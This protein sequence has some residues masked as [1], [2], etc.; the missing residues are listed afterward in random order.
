MRLL[1]ALLAAILCPLPG[2]A[3][4]AEKPNIIVIM[5]DDLGYGD[6]GCYGAKPKDLKTPHIDR[7]AANGLR[8]TSGYCS[9]STCTPTRFSFLTGKYAFR[10]KNTGIAPPNGPAIIQPGVETLPSLLKRAGYTTAVIGK[11]HLGLGGPGGPDWNGDLKPGPLEIG[12]DH[13]FLLPTTNDRVPQVYVEN[14]RV[15]NLDP[16]DPLWVGRK[17]PSPDH[18]TGLT[19][20]DTLKMDWSHGHNSTIHNGISRIGFYTGGH[21]ARFRDEDLA[22]EWVKQSNQWI[23]ANKANPFF[24]FFSSHD[25]HVPRIP[26]ERFHGTSGLGFRGDAI[27]Q[28]DWCVGELV[29]T[30]DRLKLSDNTLI[31]FCSD[32]GPVGDDG[33]KDDALEKMGDHQPGGPFSGGKY[34]VLEGGTR[35]PFI[36]HWPGRIAPGVT[37]EMV[38]TIDFAASFAALTG[39]E[40]PKDA[41]PD[42]FDVIDALLGK[43]GAKGRSQLVQQDNGKRGNYGFRAGKWKLQRH[44]AKRRHN[45]QVNTRLQFHP[46]PRYSLFDLSKDVRE[47]DDLAKEHPKV[48]E[49]MKQRL[50][51]I[52]DSGRTRRK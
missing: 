39:V 52:I 38:C 16:K 10:Q 32:N 3:A 12:F 37:D 13:C 40:L 46:A 45:V 6:I 25:L 30:L 27:V 35:T 26:H 42:S 17:K 2:Q 36:T 7:L 50:Q 22:D 14:H 1:P 31:V 23:E 8:F 33:Y 24:L 4:K 49:R 51:K 21:A 29:K 28:L 44:D 34:S 43:E 15:K 5:A 48:L 47:Q 41:C 18:P 20:R 11:W 19:H 9:A